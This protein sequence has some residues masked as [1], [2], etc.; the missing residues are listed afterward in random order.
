MVLA[1]AGLCY[2]AF[3]VATKIIG[4]FP[5]EGWASLMVVLLIVSGT[6]MVM[7]GILGEYLWRTLDQVR[8]RPLFLVMESIGTPSPSEKAG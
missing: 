1:L 5:V 7:L 3:V 4:G 6:Q 2:A 8:S